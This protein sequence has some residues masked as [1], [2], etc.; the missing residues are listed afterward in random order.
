MKHGVVLLP[1]SAAKVTLGPAQMHGQLLIAD[2]ALHR[3]AQHHVGKGSPHYVAQLGE[4]QVDL[5]KALDRRGDGVL[6]QPGQDSGVGGAMV[7]P[8]KGAPGLLVNVVAHGS[9]HVPIGAG[10]GSGAIGLDSLQSRRG[11]WF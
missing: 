11:D 9:A 5:V 7:E 3:L 4:V 1:A 2:V 8:G 10:K 6:P